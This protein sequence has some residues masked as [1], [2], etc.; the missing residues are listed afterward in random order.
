MR[1]ENLI[2]LI[3]GKLLTTPAI[4]AVSGIAFDPSEVK[5][6]DIYICLD[7][8]QTSL[9]I[10]SKAGAHALV[11]DNSTTITDSEIA[12]IEVDNLDMALAR[13]ARFYIANHNIATYKLNNL[14]VALAKSMGIPKPIMLIENDLI[15]LLYALWD[16]N[17]P[18]AIIGNN[19]LLLERIAPDA[20]TLKNYHQEPKILPTSTLFYT[21]FVLEERFYQHVPMP[22]FW[23]EAFG[24]VANLFGSFGWKYTNLKPLGHFTPLFVD[25][26]LSLH[27]FGS[28]RKALI[29]EPDLK[30]FKEELKYLKSRYKKSDIFV[31]MPKKQ[32]SQIEAD[33]IYE[34]EDEI[35]K[36]DSK[37][38]RYA[39]ILGDIPRIERL[40]QS[41]ESFKQPTLF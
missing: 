32:A 35:L 2:R 41:L 10:A 23:V 18:L 13:L 30:L 40:L 33:F 15:Q 12:W 6:G 26:H 4:S 7:R 34:K 24:R 11:F 1:L 8:L 38:F 5:P 37:N 27:P 16:A 25:K 3:Q 21:C 31:C 20:T 17:L 39:L 22:P 36:L 19:R 9:E 29:I 14:E 28:T